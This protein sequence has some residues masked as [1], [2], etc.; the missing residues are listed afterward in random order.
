MCATC[1]DDKF[2]S[3]CLQDN[4]VL[5]IIFFL[6]QKNLTLKPQERRVNQGVP[7][8]KKKSAK[9]PNGLSLEP[10]KNNYHHHQP[11]DQ[12]NN[13]HLA[14]TQSKKKKRMSKKRAMVSVNITFN[15]FM[16]TYWLVPYSPYC[17]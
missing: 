1:C 8:P 15:V 12:E 9:V 3:I 11:S 6:L 16:E 10:F 4:L 5:F 7:F 14:R 17:E 2:Y 13:P